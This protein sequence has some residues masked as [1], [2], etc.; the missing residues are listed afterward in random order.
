MAFRPV[1]LDDAR[2][3][4]RCLLEDKPNRWR[5]TV[6]V[7]RRAEELA[8]TI[9]DDDPRVL[10]AAA[11]LHDIG[12]ADEAQDT[13]FH[14]L[15]GARY[16]DRRRWPARINALVAHHSGA[17][18]LAAERGLAGAL[19]AYRL[20]QTPLSDALTYADQTV[21]PDGRRM[22]V[23]ERMAEVLTRRGPD[24]PHT[25]AHHRRRPELL[26]VAARVTGRLARTASP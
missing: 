19:A 24:S 22:T 25:R 13:G 1:R 18:F 9:G 11:W 23:H 12:Y 2:D 17:R 6:A 10:L 8:A 16:L 26:A 14:P 4:A 5:H 3:L 15:D 7:A 21:G 20:E